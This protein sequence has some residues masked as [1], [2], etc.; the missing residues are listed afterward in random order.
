MWVCRRGSNGCPSTAAPR[1]ARPAAEQPSSPPPLSRLIPPMPKLLS[2]R[3]AERL[4][5]GFGTDRPEFQA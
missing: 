1:S 4:R 2:P 3:D 5:G